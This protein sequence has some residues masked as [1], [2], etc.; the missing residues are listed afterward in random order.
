MTAEASAFASP[1][2]ECGVSQ[3]VDNRGFLRG[4]R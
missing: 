3:K 2:T 4:G 1:V